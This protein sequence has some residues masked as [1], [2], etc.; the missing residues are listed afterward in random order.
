MGKGGRERLV[1]ILPPVLRALNPVK[2][3]IGKVFIQ[4]HPDT[5]SKKFHAIAKAAGVN[6]RLHDLR[7]SCAT[8]LLKNGVP[9]EVVQKILGHANISTTKIYAEVLDEV[10]AK[11]MKKLRFK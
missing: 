2:K 3:D 7:H 5:V 8:Y 9:M 1:P 4:Y 6:A 10:M 11:E